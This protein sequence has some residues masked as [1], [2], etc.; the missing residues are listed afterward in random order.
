L[1]EQKLWISSFVP[2]SCPAKSL[3]GKPSTANLLAAI[4][5][6]ELFQSFVLRRQA[7][8]RG[9]VYDEQDFA[10]VVGE[11]GALAIDCA[12]GDVVKRLGHG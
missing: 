3:A 8:F 1:S 10:A 12:Y 4:R 11:R 9:D 7:A 5:F 6:V 2:G